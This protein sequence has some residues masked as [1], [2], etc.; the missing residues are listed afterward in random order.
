[1]CGV[2]EDF[3]LS[4]SR[5][6][7]LSARSRGGLAFTDFPLDRQLWAWETLGRLFREV[8]VPDGESLL[9]RCWGHH[10]HLP[11]DPCM[12]AAPPDRPATPEEAWGVLTR[13]MCTGLPALGGLYAR[14]L[15]AV[16]SPANAE[17]A[18]EDFAC[19]F[20]G[21]IEM[22]VQRAMRPLLERGATIGE[23]SH[24]LGELIPEVIAWGKREAERYA[25]ARSE[26]APQLMAEYEQLC[27]AG[28]DPKDA[29]DKVLAAR[30]FRLPIEMLKSDDA[31]PAEL[32]QKVITRMRLVDRR[33]IPTKTT[34][35]CLRR[36]GARLPRRLPEL[37]GRES[38][39]ARSPGSGEDDGDG[40][41]P[42]PPVAPRPSS[43]FPSP[44][45]HARSTPAG[46]RQISAAVRALRRWCGA[47]GI[48]WR[49]RRAE[50]GP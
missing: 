1:M 45:S 36:N 29:R 3:D 20:S 18:A 22:A 28:V 21:E 9:G 39:G 5:V 30:E 26:L 47:R 23:I 25:S 34:A 16:M 37:R 43:R 19:A 8:C 2:D 50:A 49:P 41:D 44:E 33:R 10:R 15:T 4:D 6:N 46:R 12:P 42:P 32:A 7:T 38:H 17:R 24:H 35:S 48:A 31:T 27:A 11:N 40:G 13:V 14:R